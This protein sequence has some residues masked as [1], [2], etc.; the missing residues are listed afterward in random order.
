MPRVKKRKL[1]EEPKDIPEVLQ[2]EIARLDQR[3]KVWKISRYTFKCYLSP[4]VW[5]LIG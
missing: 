5:N 1:E 2:G 4:Q 3:F